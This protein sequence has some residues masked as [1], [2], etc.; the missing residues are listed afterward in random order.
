[1]NRFGRRGCGGGAAWS[2]VEW[3]GWVR[4]AMN[5]FVRRDCGLERG[6]VVGGIEAAGRVRF[7]EQ[8][9]LGQNCVPA[10]PV[11]GDSPILIPSNFYTRVKTL[12]GELV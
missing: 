7:G 11:L 4:R 6:R 5:R 3:S 8:N 12:R 1:M 9:A 2:A 10:G